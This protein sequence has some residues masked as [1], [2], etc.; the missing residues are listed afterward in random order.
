[1]PIELESLT[2]EER[3]DWE[4][5]LRWYGWYEDNGWVEDAARPLAWAD[6]QKKHQRLEEF[7]GVT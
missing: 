7:S 1:M 2:S 3:Y 4:H 5:L 6:L